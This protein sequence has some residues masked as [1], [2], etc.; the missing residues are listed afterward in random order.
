MSNKPITVLQMWLI[1]Q[2]RSEPRTTQEL[3][4]HINEMYGYVCKQEIQDALD[5]LVE[6]GEIAP[7]TTGKYKAIGEMKLYYLT[8]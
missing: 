5:V 3:N 8:Y 7:S 6:I 1:M 2:L 4:D